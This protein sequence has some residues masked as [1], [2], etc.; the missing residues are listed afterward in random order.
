MDDE[1]N[2]Q[3]EDV[4]NRENS[5][6]EMDTGED[7]ITLDTENE[8]ENETPAQTP[9][10]LD[11]DDMEINKYLGTMKEYSLRLRLFN[12]L[13]EGD[14]ILYFAFGIQISTVSFCWIWIRY[15]G[16]L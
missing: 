14:L 1:E 15:N 11:R 9:A 5:E 6:N 10:H 16:R 2:S 4:Q 8:F 12:V 7:E 13:R 3:N